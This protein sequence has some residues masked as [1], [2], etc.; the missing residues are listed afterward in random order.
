MESVKHSFTILVLHSEHGQIHA[1]FA[2]F[3]GKSRCEI[4]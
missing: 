1:D 4:H 3:L 2:M